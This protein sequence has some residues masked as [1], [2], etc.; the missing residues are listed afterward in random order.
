[1]SPEEELARLQ[2]RLSALKKEDEIIALR[3][4][5]ARKEHERSVLGRLEKRLSR[6]ADNILK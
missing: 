6:V 3:E 5:I 2:E 4:E 1:M